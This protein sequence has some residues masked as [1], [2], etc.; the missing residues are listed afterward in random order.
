MGIVPERCKDQMG[1]ASNS[2]DTCCS[3][4]PEVRNQSNRG[5]VIWEADHF[6]SSIIKDTGLT[7]TTVPISTAPKDANTTG[8]ALCCG[9]TAFAATICVAAVGPV[10]TAVIIWATF[11][12][13]NQD[14]PLAANLCDRVDAATL[15]ANHVL[16][17][18][19]A[20]LIVQCARKIHAIVQLD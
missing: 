18:T 10:E 6:A 3:S 17:G 13:V 19:A 4:R 11:S 5:K 7:G 1:R 20:V 9:E 15:C 8:A 12:F 2:L 16:C 14:S